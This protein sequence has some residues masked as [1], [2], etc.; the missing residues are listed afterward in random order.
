MLGH[1]QKDPSLM[2][3]NNQ[4]EQAAFSPSNTVDGWEPSADPGEWKYHT[5]I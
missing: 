1:W 2:S 4:V 3:F 5:L